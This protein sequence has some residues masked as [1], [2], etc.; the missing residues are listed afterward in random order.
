[1]EWLVLRIADDLFEHLSASLSPSMNIPASCK[2]LTACIRRA[3]ELD[4]DVTNPD[5]KVISYYCKMYAMEKGMKLKAASGAADINP[6][7]MSL[8]TALERDKQHVKMT[9]D[10]AAVI[11][12]NFAHSVFSRADDEDRA[13]LA[14]MDT[15]KTF[16][17]AQTFFEILDQFCEVDEEIA[18]KR[19]YSKWKATDI[20][21]AIKA[22][23]IPTPGD[24]ANSGAMPAQGLAKMSIQAHVTQAADSINFCPQHLPFVPSIIPS[25]PTFVPPAPVLTGSKPLPAPEGKVKDTI[26]YCSFA[27]AALKH[28]DI[29]LAKERLREALRILEN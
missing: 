20:T 5:S 29:I 16:Y 15:A 18:E 23:K 3:E 25:A 6:L 22:G 10:E 7:L 12:E 28:N 26:E 1:M 21:N 9:K 24:P 2:P 17:A 14:T 8:M 11:C 13:G 27:I 4:R 19:K